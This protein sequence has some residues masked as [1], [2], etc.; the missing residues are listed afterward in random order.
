M[1]RYPKP[2]NLSVDQMIDGSADI[3]EMELLR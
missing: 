2:T 1:R 3:V